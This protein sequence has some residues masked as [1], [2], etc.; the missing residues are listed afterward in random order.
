MNAVLPRR[1]LLPHQV[2]I[3]LVDEGCRAEGVIG[4]F[5]LHLPMRQPPELVIDHRHQP[6]HGFFVA[7]LPLL[8]QLRDSTL[9]LR[10]HRGLWSPSRMVT[11]RRRHYLS[12]FSRTYLQNVMR[13]LENCNP[14]VSRL[15]WLYDLKS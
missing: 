1:L 5:V 14:P 6:V 12:R 3:R 13:A 2:Q 7:L 11:P 4:A 8:Q 15:G 10:D 9:V